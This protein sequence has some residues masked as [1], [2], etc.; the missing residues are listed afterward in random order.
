MPPG[1]RAHRRHTLV[2]GVGLQ[3]RQLETLGSPSPSNLFLPMFKMHHIC[4]GTSSSARFGV[5]AGHLSATSHGAYWTR[6]RVKLHEAVGIVETMQ[7]GLVERLVGSTGSS[8]LPYPTNTGTGHTE[9]GDDENDE[10]EQDHDK[11]KRASK[12]SNIPKLIR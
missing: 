12:S 3:R 11:G 6:Q 8:I 7:R 5:A 1:V 9:A 4:R 10:N 2:L